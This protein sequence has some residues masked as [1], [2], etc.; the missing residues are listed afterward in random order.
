MNILVTGSEG[1]LAQMLIPHLLGEGHDVVGVDNFARYGEKEGKREY[2]FHKGD[3]TR[4]DVVEGLFSE[5]DFDVVFHN[6]ALIYG[7]VGF[8]KKPADILADNNLMTMSL[9]KYGKDKV[10]KFIYMSSS[11]VYEMCRTVPHREEDADK[12][13]VM[14]TA[15]GLSKYIGERVVRSFHDQFGTKYTIWRPFNIITPFETPEE[16]GFSH[17][18]SDMV[19]KIIGERQNPLE[20]FGDGNQIRCFTNINDVADAII[21]YSLDSRSDN[22]AFNI[23]NPEPLKIRELVELIVDLGK[24]KGVLPSD[25]EIEYKHL[26]IYSDDVKKRIPDVSKMERVFGW[27]AKVKA[28]E[29]LSQ[30]IDYYAENMMK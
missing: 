16:S 14:S 7:V 8:H 1:S 13:A 23:G 22:E 19:R 17:V 6:A 20:I 26:E 21:S 9:L 5:Y 12:S 24:E 10:S 15:Y 2:D 4:T 27:K 3:L 28:R 18:F 29:S 11:M 30:Y 25:Y